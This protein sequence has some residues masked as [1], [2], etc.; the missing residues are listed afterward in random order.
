[1]AG[2]G[3]GFDGGEGGGQRELI[4]DSI[5]SS[6]G[7]VWFEGWTAKKGGRFPRT[8]EKIEIKLKTTVKVLSD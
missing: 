7:G 4:D 2:A 3:K 8:F 6:R 5:E 1:M